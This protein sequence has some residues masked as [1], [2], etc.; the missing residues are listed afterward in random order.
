MPLIIKVFSPDLDLG[1]PRKLVLQ[2]ITLDLLNFFSIQLL[3]Y[4]NLIF[5]KSG[6]R[7]SFHKN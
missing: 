4:A 1:M 5:I 7:E 6:R 3:C 2:L